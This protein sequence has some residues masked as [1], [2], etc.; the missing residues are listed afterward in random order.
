[1]TGNAGDLLDILL[2]AAP[3][4]IPQGPSLLARER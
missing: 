3:K 2:M 4:Q 1:M